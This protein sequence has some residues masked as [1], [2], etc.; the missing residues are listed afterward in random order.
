MT[1]KDIEH[2][3]E[4]GIAENAEFDPVDISEWLTVLCIHWLTPEET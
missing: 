4:P 2:R 3:V 1:R